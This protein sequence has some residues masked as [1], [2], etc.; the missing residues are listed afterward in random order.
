[1]N[2]ENILIA[3]GLP[4]GFID[5][6]PFWARV[7]FALAMFANWIGP[8]RGD[9]TP[10][11][12]FG[13]VPHFDQLLIRAAIRMLLIVSHLEGIDEWEEEKKATEIVLDYIS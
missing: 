8:R 4:P 2:A 1:M 11:R 13:D 10:L 9:P 5:L 6:T 3:P 12:H 7:D